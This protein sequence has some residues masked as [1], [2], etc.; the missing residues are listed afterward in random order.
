M[1]ALEGSKEGKGEVTPINKAVP[2]VRHRQSLVRQ[3]VITHIFKMNS[4]RSLRYETCGHTPHCVFIL[5]TSYKER[6]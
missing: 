4:F 3:D 1:K 6:R 5:R 2:E